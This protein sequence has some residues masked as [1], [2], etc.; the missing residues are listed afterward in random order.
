MEIAPTTTPDPTA[1]SAVGT[2]GSGL[3]TDA[4][5]DQMGRDEFLK[6]LMAQLEHQDPMSPMENHEFV[7][8]LATFSGL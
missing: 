3:L 1:A 8:Q 2:S 6:L 4:T 7:A 5:A